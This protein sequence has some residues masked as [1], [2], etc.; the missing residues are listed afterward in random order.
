MLSFITAGRARH[1]SAADERR[2]VSLSLLSHCRLRSS[3]AGHLPYGTTP[4]ERRHHSIAHGGATSSHKHY[5]WP[6]SADCL[7]LYIKTP[8]LCYTPTRRFARADT[9][10]LRPRWA[11]DAHDAMLFSRRRDTTI[12]LVKMRS[13]RAR[14][15]QRECR[16]RKR[17]LAAYASNAA[18]LRATSRV[19][20]LRFR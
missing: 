19:T 16:R 10:A 2:S 12:I 4:H 7:F 13:F 9:R 3:K 20:G 8:H 18:S 6:L 11:A 17:K 1:I 14:I 15:Y 5:C